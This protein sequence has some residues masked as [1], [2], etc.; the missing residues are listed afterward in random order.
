[1]NEFSLRG[2]VLLGAASSAAQIDG[3]R[4]DHNWTDWYEKGNIKDGSNPALATEHWLRWREDV[5]LMRRMGI[6]T[7]RMSIDW[8]RV[9][10]R[11][12]EFDQ[13]A[14]G[15]I[16]EELMLLIGMGIKPLVT[17]HHF[18]NPMWFEEKGGWEHYGNILCFLVYVE[19]MVRAIGHLVSEYV[20]INEP[21][22]YAYNGYVNG[23]WPPGRKSYAAAAA[24]M[25][26]MASAHIKCYRLIHDLRRSLGFRDTKVGFALQ[27]RVF[28]PKSGHNPAH[29]VAAVVSERAFQTY[30]AR[31]MIT[32]EFKS[33]LKN[34][35]R[36]RR[37]TYADFHG[38][39][40][41]G[42]V[43]VSGMGAG[44]AEGS[45]KNDLGW[46]I[47]PEGLVQCC[48]ALAEIRPMPIYITGNGTCDLTDSFRA[49]FIYE[50]LKAM[51][52]SKLPIKRYYHWCF[53]D[54]FEW[55]E[56]FYARF[57]LVRTDFDTM[58]RTV[59]GSGEFYSEIIKNHGVSEEMYEKY[60]AE[61][62]YHF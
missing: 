34:A 47:Y 3:G 17:L 53:N 61:E 51:S 57:G 62:K 37:G 59:K 39:D 20:T 45:C 44:A 19:T 1:M 31:A 41:Y 38:V 60:V 43:A 29:S 27:M 2:G 54:C 7:Y 6:Q 21:N 25:S 9:E 15:H 36:D 24:V 4:L 49:R 5:L 35:G 18:T 48:Q 26:N 13:R 16:K 55:N 52:G 14:I 40:Y 56:G 32:G 8:A 46:E 12:G 22:T 11:E 28:R 50:H 30:L 33:P 23:S 10:P 58:E 42:G